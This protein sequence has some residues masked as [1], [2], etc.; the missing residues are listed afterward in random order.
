MTTTPTGAASAPMGRARA[1]TGAT[2][3]HAIEFFDFTVFGFLAVHI[4]HNFFPSGDPTA[5]LLSSF[6]VFGLAFFARP[7]GGLIFGPLADRIGR[8]QVLVLVLSLMSGCSLLIG[9][10]PTYE[11]WGIAA[12]VILVFLRLLQGFSAGGEYSSGSAF[13][14]EFAGPGR[15]A[16]GVSWLTFGTTVGLTAGLLTVTG[17]TAVLSEDDMAE[18]GWRIPFLMAAPLAAIALYIRAKI[19][20]TPEFQAL[21]RTEQISAAP[22]REVVKRKRGL[23]LIVGIGAMHATC[24]YAVFTYMPTYIGTVNSYGA[25]FAL[26]STLVSAAVTMIV[27][28]VLATVSDRVGRRPVLI[29]GALGFAALVFPVFGGITVGNPALAMASQVALGVL[30]ATYLSASAA[31]MPELFPASVRSTGVAVGFNIPAA[32]FG[33]GAPFVATYLIDLTGWT[34]A[35]AM[36]LLGTALIGLVAALFLRSGDIHGDEIVEGQRLGR[37]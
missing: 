37:V 35:P 25:T 14:L 12:P 29:A 27:L 1:I 15:R 26:I 7:L 5:E 16:F 19:E 33:G 10:L 28:P 8:K 18:W 2:A 20:D 23:A 6:A 22:V 3:G 36:Y 31:A 34:V 11:S 13:L 21:A 32:V 17:V 9:L 24:F 30:T 4:G